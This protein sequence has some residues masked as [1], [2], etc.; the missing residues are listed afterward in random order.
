MYCTNRVDPAFNNDDT[1][2]TVTT[3]MICPA[4]SPDNLQYLVKM[5]SWIRVPP[6][7]KLISNCKYELGDKVEIWR[8]STPTLQSVSVDANY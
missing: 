1:V 7:Y 2:T 6:R 5:Q 3:I 4:T 8:S